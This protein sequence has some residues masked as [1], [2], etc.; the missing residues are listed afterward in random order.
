MHYVSYD[1]H[2][3]RSLFSLHSMKRG[4]FVNVRL[5]GRRRQSGHKVEVVQVMACRVHHRAVLRNRGWEENSLL[6]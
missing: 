4:A 5:V 6:N 3:K 1:S 2:S